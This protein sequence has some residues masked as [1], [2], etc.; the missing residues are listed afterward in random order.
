MTAAG[1]IYRVGFALLDLD[2]PRVL[3]R[4][5]DE[6]VIG[7]TAPYE[8]SGD[9]NKVVF[10]TGWLVDDAATEI[11]LYYG[12]GDS[13]IAVATA[14]LDD[15]LTYMWQLTRPNGGDIHDRLSADTEAVAEIG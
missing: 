9:I 3:L 4:R 8:R 12:A 5:T 2:D 11:S 10:P 1:P 13:V 15:L 14:P 6:W 7:P